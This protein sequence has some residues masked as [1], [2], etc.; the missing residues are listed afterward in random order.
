MARLAITSQL[1]T[2]VVIAASGQFF[3]FV[4][5]VSDYLDLF[6]VCTAHFPLSWI[7]GSPPPRLLTFSQ[8]E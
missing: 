8:R 7:D 1:G 6:G 5:A 3:V 4:V 2:T